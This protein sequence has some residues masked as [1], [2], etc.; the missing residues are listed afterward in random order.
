MMMMMMMMMMNIF[1]ISSRTL[2][3]I[4]EDNC[5]VPQRLGEVQGEH[6]DVVVSR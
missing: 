3:W 1:M 4:L 6:V 2:Y 5:S